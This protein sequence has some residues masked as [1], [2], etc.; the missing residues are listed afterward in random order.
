[1]SFDG[2]VTRTLVPATFS[3]SNAPVMSIGSLPFGSDR[4]RP[5]RIDFGRAGHLQNSWAVGS[6]LDLLLQGQSSLNRYVVMGANGYSMKA[7]SLPRRIIT[8]FIIRR[9]TE[10]AFVP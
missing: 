3:D 4:P 6:S 9:L 1:M 2:D 8:L 7:S 5:S 10:N